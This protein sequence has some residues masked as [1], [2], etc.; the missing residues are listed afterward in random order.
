MAR[1]KV[2]RQHKF[3]PYMEIWFFG[4]SAVYLI[5][6][7]MEFKKCRNMPRWFALPQH[8]MKAGDGG[9]TTYNFGCAKSGNHMDLG[10][11]L[12]GS[13]EVCLLFHQLLDHFRW[14]K[15]FRTRGLFHNKRI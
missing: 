5:H 10:Q 2:K 13:Y 7:H 4:F 6:I 3:C 11:L 15:K 9:H 8:G 1:V 14:N 12:M